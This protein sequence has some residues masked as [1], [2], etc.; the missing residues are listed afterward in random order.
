MSASQQ[1][2]KDYHKAATA[3]AYNRYNQLPSGQLESE[4]IHIALS[5]C[6]GHTILNLGGG[7]GLHALKAINLGDV[8]V[9]VVDIS[10]AML[11]ICRQHVEAH[12][13]SL[14]RVAVAIPKAG[15]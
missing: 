11:Q 9:D 6:T 10:P 2:K 13:N 3:T 4:L 1:A 5:D 15:G 14:R 7:T 8:A 12:N